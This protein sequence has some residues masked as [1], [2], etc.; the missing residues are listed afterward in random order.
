MKVAV[1]LSEDFMIVRLTTRH[2]NDSPPSGMPSKAVLHGR[3][4]F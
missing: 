1:I 3:Q 2:E 4:E